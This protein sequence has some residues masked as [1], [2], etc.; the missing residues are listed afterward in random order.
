MPLFSVVIPIYNSE[1]T[2]AETLNSLAHQSFTDFEVILVNDGSTDASKKIIENWRSNHPSI[3]LKLIGQANSGLGNS[4]NVAIKHAIG[5]YVCF[6]DADDIWTKHK[7]QKLARFHEMNSSDFIYHPVQSF[8]LT[9][10]KKRFCYPLTSIQELMVKGNPIVPSAVC[11]KTELARKHPFST[12]P[13]F[14]GAEDLLLW[15]Q[16]MHAGYAPSYLNEHLTLY[17]EDGGMSTNL[18]EHYQNVFHVFEH[19]STQKMV[20]PDLIKAAVKRKNY[21]A[22]RFFQKRKHF[23]LAESYYSQSAKYSS[24]TWLLRLSNFLGLSF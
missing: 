7:L 19:S 11:L 17:R 16:L 12:N 13:K 24:K 10:P 5:D 4:R 2:L 1:T 22:A 3:Q 21:E 15:I 6:L 23:A 18:K 8:G 20:N 9:S 14:H